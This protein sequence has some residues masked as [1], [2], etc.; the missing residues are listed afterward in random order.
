MSGSAA[1]TGA[2]DAHT[3]RGTQKDVTALNKIISKP[4]EV[5][6]ADYSLQA[7]VEQQ[8]SL[9]CQPSAA[10]IGAQNKISKQPSTDFNQYLKE[11]TNEYLK[12][13]NIMNQTGQRFESPTT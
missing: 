5:A 13:S 12:N 1:R 11:P 3:T 6:K 9:S 8:V 10:R 7:A 4:S 2:F